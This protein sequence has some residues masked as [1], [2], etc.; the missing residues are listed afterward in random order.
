MSIKSRISV[1]ILA[2]MPRSAI[3]GE[4]AGRGSG[5]LATWL[6]QLARSLSL[7]DGLEIS[8]LTFDQEVETLAVDEAFGQ[9]F[10]RIPRGKITWD[11]IFWHAYARQKLLSVLGKIKPD[12][13][14]VWGSEN[15][16]P[17]VLKAVKVPTIMSM[18][19]IL[20]EYSRIGSFANNWRMR[21]QS[22]YESG[23]V[24]AASIITSES[25][26]G[27]N[28]VREMHP[29]AVGR[30]V[31]YGVH[32]SFY[33][34]RW[35]PNPSEP[36]L[37]FC[38]GLDSRKGIDVILDALKIDPNF[39]WK[40]W[41]AGDGEYR[42][43]IER[44]NFP[45]VE[46]LGNI[47]WKELQERLIRAW[48][49][50]LPTRADTSPNVVKEARVVGLPVITSALGGQAGYIKNGEN[51]LIIDPLT[52]KDLRL[53]MDNMTKNLERALKM[54]ATNHAKDRDYFQP[55][56]TSKSFVEIY[57]EL[58]DSLANERR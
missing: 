28:K 8:W 30:L 13:V 42:N 19:G 58:H 16:Y 4:A 22:T 15:S 56:N 53:A 55:S 14:H 27:L 20:T 26:W 41:I 18:Q 57:H 23:W 1:A 3:K 37:L 25:E 38:G 36:A 43:E 24:K 10:Y 50:V 40:L 48:G 6:P 34:I 17:S 11:I 7:D 49:L 54:G 12:I 45:Q 35:N 52:S 5:Q 39:S 29:S 44:L 9:K 51:G 21:R 2:D 47:R 46:L 33:E 31:E 32:P